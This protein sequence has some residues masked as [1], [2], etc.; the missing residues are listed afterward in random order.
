[1]NSDTFL[2]RELLFSIGL[3]T[4]ILILSPRSYHKFVMLFRQMRLSNQIITTLGIILFSFA[5][6][7]FIIGLMNPG[8]NILLHS[9][10]QVNSESWNTSLMIVIA[11]IFMIFVAFRLHKTQVNK[12]NT[13]NGE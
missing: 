5:L 3:L 4:I 13:T 11:G 6:D 10:M 1:M 12:S 9:F 2:F 8:L 7:D